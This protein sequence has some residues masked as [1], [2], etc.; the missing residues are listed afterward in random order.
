MH[1]LP[2]PFPAA[3]DYV[4]FAQGVRDGTARSSVVVR[5]GDFPDDEDISD[6]R[7]VEAVFNPVG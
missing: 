1:P 6:H 4:F 3:P 5:E 2:G 7:P